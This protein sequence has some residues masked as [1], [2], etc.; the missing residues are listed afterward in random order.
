MLI[1]LAESSFACLAY[2]EDEPCKLYELM[3]EKAG[4][5]QTSLLLDVI[6][7]ETRKHRELLNHLSRVFEHESFAR[8]EAE[9]E[10]EL[11]E[12]FTQA[13]AT[14]HS[15]KDEVLRGTPV[16]EAAAKLVDFERS[17]S[18]EYLTELHVG[19]AATTETNQAVKKILEGIAEDEVGHV[20]ILKLIVEMAARE[21]SP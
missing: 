6:L 7:Q 12:L 3:V 15:V 2:L 20:Q 21:R 19:V 9:C 1:S 8:A 18:E 11:G 13:L 10:R 4:E 14:V 16:A 5:L 17:A